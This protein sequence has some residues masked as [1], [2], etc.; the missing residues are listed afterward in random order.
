MRGFLLASVSS[1]ALASTAWAADLSTKAPPAAI[2]V[3]PTWSGFYI[4]LDGG[5]LQNRATVQELQPGSIDTSASLTMDGFIGGG[6]LGY[7][8]QYQ[9]F[10]LGVEADI[11]AGTG[12]RTTTFL[13]G[14]DTFTSRINWLSTIRGR[15]GVTFDQWLLYGTAGW[16]VAGVHNTRT[17]TGGPFILDETKAKSGF[18]WGGGVERMFTPH[19]SGRVEALAVDL[20]NDTVTTVTPN[21]PYTTRF[22][23][24]A[25]IARGGVS[26]KW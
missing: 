5:W 19:W 20:G 2:P 3:A 15:L 22:T 18:I 1:A 4:G 10:L 23:N 6:H 11:G 16:A 21:G 24:K 13:V 14:A 17:D 25:L 26:F 7:N 9:Q 8:W 12:S